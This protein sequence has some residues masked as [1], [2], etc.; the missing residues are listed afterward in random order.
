MVTAGPQNKWK[1]RLQ[2]VPDC[3]FPS[4]YLILNIPN[5]TEGQPVT[6]PHQVIFARRFIQHTSFLCP[7]TGLFGVPFLS[8]FLTL[9]RFWLGTKTG[10]LIRFGRPKN[11]V[12]LSFPTSPLRCCEPRSTH[13]KIAEGKGSLCFKDLGGGLFLSA[14]PIKD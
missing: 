12:T 8:G 6:P 3:K 2:S 7:W 1:N 11:L 10:K 14:R 5:Y 4:P 13:L 9:P